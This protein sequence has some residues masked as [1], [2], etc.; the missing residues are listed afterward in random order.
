L[1]VKAR[2][3]RKLPVFRPWEAVLFGVITLGAIA[4]VVS[5]ITG[6]IEI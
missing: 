4:G 2:R 1:Y 3:E 6:A 5:L